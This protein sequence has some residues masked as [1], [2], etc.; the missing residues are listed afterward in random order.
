MLGT[1]KIRV[2]SSHY[3][4]KSFGL[5]LRSLALFRIGLALVIII[6]LSY[7]LSDLKAHY[8]D[9][10]ILPRGPLLEKFLD[11][12]Y[13]SFHLFSGTVFY[14]SLLF[15][16]AIFIA[17]LLLVGFRTRTA[18]ILSWIL[19]VSLHNRNPMVLNSGD[20]ELRLLLFWAIF[21]P[22]G[23]YYSVDSALDTNF[24]LLPKRTISLCTLALT[25]QVCFVYWFAWLHK[26]DPIWHQEGSAVYYALSIDQFA[27]P[28]GHFLL[29]FPSLLSFTTI[30][31]LWIELL[32]PFLLFIPFKNDFFRLVTVV[33]FILLH[34]SFRAG[35]EIGLFAVISIVAWLAF[36]PSLF[37]NA[38]Q[39]QLGGFVNLIFKLRPFRLLGKIIYNL[40]VKINLQNNFLCKQEFPHSRKT[41]YSKINNLIVFI[42]ILCVTLWNLHTFAPNRYK[43]PAL[44]REINLALRLD[45]KWDMF[46]PYPLI[47]DGW[48]VI[49]G[50]LTDGTK[51]NLFQDDQPITWEKPSLVS[52]TYPNQRWRKYMMNL[53]MKKNSEYRL[54]YGKYLCN[55]WNNRHE[56][57]QKLQKFS[58]Y[59]MLEQTLPNYQKPTIEKLNLWNHY[60][61]KE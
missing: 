50:I 56:N 41:N 46:A 34:L 19:L 14:Q 49:P 21:L 24:Q 37:W 57:N 52:G 28:F 17:F 30:V 54:Y 60:C 36:I 22:L 3:I 11:H 33:T 53:H 29:K 5:D 38:I 9:F 58:I 43:L 18:T 45:Q 55:N 48:Y 7:R 10:G 1:S 31:T 25:M 51:V 20:V 4:E 47:D 59:F 44:V 42:L 15:I 16:I 32:V 12:R 26:S 40:L 23:A 35:L 8:T 13:W 2:I 61:F 39:C 27:T 6:D